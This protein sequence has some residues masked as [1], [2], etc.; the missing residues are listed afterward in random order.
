VRPS[1]V[2][3]EFVRGASPEIGFPW[4]LLGYPAAAIWV[5]SITII[6][7]IYGLSFLVAASMHSSHGRAR[8]T[9]YDSHAAHLCSGRDGNS[10][11]RRA[12]WTRLVP[13]PPLSFA[14]AVQLNFP[15]VESYPR[16]GSRHTRRISTKSHESA[17]PLRENA[18][19]SGVA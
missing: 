11:E 10:V 2:T 16:I 13:Q 5:R 4:N 18:R 6:T 8:R 3:F 12:G 1:L 7:G 14:R 15:E 9:D 19:P 17:L